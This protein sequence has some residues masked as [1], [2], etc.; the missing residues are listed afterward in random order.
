MG[1]TTISGRISSTS[2]SEPIDLG[3]LF[4][5]VAA[6]QH[7]KPDTL[8]KAAAEADPDNASE[9]LHWG[10][11]LIVLGRPS[12]KRNARKLLNTYLTHADQPSGS[13]L[14]ANLLLKQ[15]QDELT[16]KRS[17]AKGIEQRDELSKQLE[18]RKRELVERMQELEGRDHQLEGRTQQLWELEQQLDELETQLEGIKHIEVEMQD[19]TRIPHL[20]LTPREPKR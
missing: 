7:A 8:R 17:V 4:D 14:L 12:D 20:E 5:D 18:G 10:L 1:C 2:A 3:R 19:R 13:V 6:L 11:V 15:L 9:L 16:L